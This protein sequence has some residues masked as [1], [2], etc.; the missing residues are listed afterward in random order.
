MS[1]ESLAE[2]LIHRG[3]YNPFPKIR[4]TERPD[5]AAA[6]LEEGSVIIVCDNSPQVMMLPT[7]IFDFLQ[8]TDDFYFPPLSGTYLRI[9]RMFIFFLAFILTP[10]WYLLIKTPDSLPSWL[11]FINI[12]EPAAVPLLMRF[13]LRSL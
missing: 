11:E 2:C 4:Y 7:G 10:L 8:E 12:N 6:M 3:W 1:Q 5:T 13:C 9:T